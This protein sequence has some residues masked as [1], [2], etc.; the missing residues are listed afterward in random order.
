MGSFIS[1]SSF[2]VTERQELENDIDQIRRAVR[3]ARDES[4]LRSRIVRILINLEEEP[5]TLKVEYAEDSD[6]IIPSFLSD[7]DAE[8]S[9]ANEDALEKKKKK[10]E[11]AFTSVAEFSD[12]PLQF[13]P[14]VV[15]R[16]IG[17]TLLDTIFSEGEI[18]LFFY[19]SGEKDGGFFLLSTYEEMAT[20]KYGPFTEEIDEESDDPD[21]MSSYFIE[22][23]KGLFSA[24][25][26]E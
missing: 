5:Q 7:P 24:W 26:K 23:G 2:F 22:K 9:K 18:S 17:S 15:V 13:S 19:P 11:Q 14:N 3:F 25:E 12:R 20:V 8:S 10:F 21:I 1:S 6:F 16:V 4:I